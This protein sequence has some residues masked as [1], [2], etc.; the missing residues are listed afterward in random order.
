VMVDL[1]EALGKQR[2][3]VAACFEGVAAVPICCRSA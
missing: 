1:A 2:Q 3:D